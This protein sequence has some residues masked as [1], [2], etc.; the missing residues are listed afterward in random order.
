[1]SF[2]FSHKYLNNKPITAIAVKRHMDQSSQYLIGLNK[3]SQNSQEILYFLAIVNN[4]ICSDL[5]QVSNKAHI[6]LNDVSIEVD[7]RA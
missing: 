1:M 5:A 3:Y 6:R 4:G 2:P 7:F